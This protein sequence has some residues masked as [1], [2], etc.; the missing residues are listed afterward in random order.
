MTNPLRS[1][2]GWCLGDHGSSLAGAPEKVPGGSL[3]LTSGQALAEDESGRRGL[4]A[5]PHTQ[6]DML[7]S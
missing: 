5:F 6:M 1:M 3:L 4:A 7:S 2:V